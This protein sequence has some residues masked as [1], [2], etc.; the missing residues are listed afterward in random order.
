MAHP[1]VRRF[2]AVFV[3][4]VLLVAMALAADP[5]FGRPNTCPDQGNLL[6]LI[7]GCN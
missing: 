6:V 7:V 5:V 1:L 4:V 3:V 2:L